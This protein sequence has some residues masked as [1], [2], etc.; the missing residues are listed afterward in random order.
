[1]VAFL[2]TTDSGSNLH[3]ALLAAWRAE[4]RD[5][6]QPELCNGYARIGGQVDLPLIYRS[7]MEQLK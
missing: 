3:A 5:L 4:K 2:V 6:A 1:M 7:W